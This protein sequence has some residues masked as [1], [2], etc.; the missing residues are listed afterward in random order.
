MGDASTNAVVFN[1]AGSDKFDDGSTSSLTLTNT[2]DQREL[3]VISISGTKRWKIIGTLLTATSTTTT[4]TVSTTTVATAQEGVPKISGGATQYGIPNSALSSTSTLALT[5]NQVRYNW[6]QVDSAI[7]VSGWQFEVT[8]GPASSANVRVG[9]YRADNDLQPVGAPLLDS[10]N[11]AVASGFTGVKNASSLSVVLQPGIYLTAVNCNVAM[12]LRTLVG[13]GSFV[14]SAFGS[15]SVVSNF[16]VSQT[17]GA[18]PLTGTK[19]T[20]ANSGSGTSNMVAFQW[21]LGEV[22]YVAD[23]ATP[24]LAA[25]AASGKR[26]VFPA[27]TTYT[28]T[29]LTIPANCYVE[30]N[31]STLKFGN[32][33]TSGSTQSDELLKVNGSGVT[34]DGLNF[35]GNSANQGAIWSQYRHCVRIMGLFSNVTVKN[36][37]FTNIIGDG[38]YTNTQAGSNIAIGPNN[39]FTANYDNRNGVSVVTGDTVEVFSNTFTNVSNSGMPGPIDIEPNNAT[40]H[41]LHVDIHDNTIIGGSTLGTGAL[42]GIVYGGFANAAAVDIK[43]RNNDISGTRFEEGILIIGISGGPFNAATG[44]VISGN[45]VH[46]IGQD[47]PVNKFGVSLNHY[48]GADVTGNTFNGMDYGI[49]NYKGCLGVSTGNTFTAITTSNIVNDDPHCS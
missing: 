47:P 41:L 26:L 23:Y 13:G 21:K 30:G 32:N 17:F 31:D 35:D 39:T 16:T 19:W 15:G 10:G 24:Q 3:Q 6:F 46:G 34:I 29:G 20:T 4:T 9:I 43:I 33:T 38:V 5:A 40:D 42:P 1:C 12:T 36:C 37:D 7:T 48:I 45:N 49:Y 18:F 25:N 22:I 14:A 11:V 2:G 44:I 8:T 27:T 28:T